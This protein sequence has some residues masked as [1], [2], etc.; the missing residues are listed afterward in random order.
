MKVKIDSGH[1]FRAR[2]A[3]FHLNL[4]AAELRD[5]VSLTVAGIILM[6]RAAGLTADR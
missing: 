4:I 1:D 6:L 2:N 5:R 3:S